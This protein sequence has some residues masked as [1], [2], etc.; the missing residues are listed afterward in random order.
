MPYPSPDLFPST[1]L[2]PGP[3]TPPPVLVPGMITG[4]VVLSDRNTGGNDDP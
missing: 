3:L 4:G 1:V 2:F